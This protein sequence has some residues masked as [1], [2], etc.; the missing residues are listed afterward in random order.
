MRPDHHAAPHRENSDHW[1]S[2]KS[3]N[4]QRILFWVLWTVAQLYSRAEISPFSR[5]AACATLR[6]QIPKLKV[7]SHQGQSPLYVSCTSRWYL[8]L[9]EASRLPPHE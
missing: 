2:H 9:G 5:N 7:F 6:K 1:K 3:T 8:G 4:S